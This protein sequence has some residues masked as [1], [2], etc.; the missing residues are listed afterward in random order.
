MPFRRTFSNTSIHKN[1]NT[2][3]HSH[4]SDKGLQMTQGPLFKKIVVFSF[5]LIITNLL[6]VFYN[7]ADMMVVGLSTEPDAVG[8]IGTTSAFINLVVN[9]F[10]G[11]STGANVIVAKHL[12]AKDDKKISSSVHTAL[13]MSIIFGLASLVIGLFI[14]NPILSIMGA[15][16]KLLELATTYTKIYFL[17]VPFISFTNYLI[18]IFRAKGDTRTPL[19]VLTSTG[20]VNVLLNM[21]FVMG[22]GLSV[23]GVALA[24][25]IANALSS[26]CLLYILS[27]DSGPC[28]FSFKKICFNV[29]AFKEIL[30][31][32]LPAGIQGSLFSISNMLIQSS[33]LQ[34]NNIISPNSGDFAPVV[35]GN[36]AAANLEGFIYTA[37]N[38]IY[39]AAITF[40]SQNV[41]AKK[42]ERIYKIM[43]NCYALGFVIALTF[44]L[45]IFFLKAPLLSLYGVVDAEVGSLEHIAYNTA[46]IRMCYVFLPYCIISFME[47]GCGIVRGLGKSISSTIISLTGACAFRVVW[48]MTIFKL[49]Q[50]LETIYI[51][52]PISW[53][54]TGLIFFIYSIVAIKKLI[55]LRDRE[56]N[57]TERELSHI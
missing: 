7:A 55:K 47:V 44:S 32:G 52:Y 28:R 45:L 57:I 10:A 42:Y 12:G 4:S 18:S 41:G 14:S 15:E 53:F 22:C 49:S 33:I 1:P 19:Y 56:T 27:R 20:V 17:G 43:K 16:G 26:F 8:A 25:T 40:T 23:E 50:T 51:S 54:L 24:T 13:L 3:R 29:T 31:I 30:Y 34:V 39:Q 37:Q 5:P 38:T 35:K 48:L 46:F 11:F 2:Y 9:V 21:F 36:A 6:Q